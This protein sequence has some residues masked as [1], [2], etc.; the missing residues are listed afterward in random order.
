[1][2]DINVKIVDREASYYQDVDTDVS[3]TFGKL[4]LFYK[5]SVVRNVCLF[6]AK[7]LKSEEE[8]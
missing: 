3:V 5:P 2:V 1:M 4:K 6:L 7:A 8:K